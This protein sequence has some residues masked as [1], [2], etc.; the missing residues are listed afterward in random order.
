MRDQIKQELMATAREE[1]GAKN[2]TRSGPRNSAPSA[3]SAAA[4]K[5]SSGDTNDNTGAFPNLT[6]ST[7]VPSTPGTQFSPVQRRSDRACP[8]PRLLRLRHFV[9]PGLQRRRPLATGDTNSPTSPNQTFGGSG[10]IQIRHLARSRLPQLGHAAPATARNH[11][12][13]GRFGQPLPLHR[14]P[15]G[16]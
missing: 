15:V 6:P 14:S 12:L 5:A 2:T 4:T 11:L 10:G 3:T 9:R 1:K 7:P 13:L 16:R 8:P